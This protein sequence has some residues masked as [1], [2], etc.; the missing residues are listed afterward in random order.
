VRA[1]LGSFPC[2][3]DKL[4]F[5]QAI[6]DRSDFF[7]LIPMLLNFR[8]CRIGLS[9]IMSMFYPMFHAISDNVLENL[10]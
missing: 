10:D 5:S 6:A 9:L 2:L 7:H 4:F 1:I 3:K 8:T